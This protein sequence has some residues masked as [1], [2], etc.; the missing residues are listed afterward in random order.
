M[1][2][3]H[4]CMV[5]RHMGSKNRNSQ[6]VAGVVSRA[7]LAGLLVGLL[8]GVTSCKGIDARRLEKEAVHLYEEGKFQEAV[9]T[10]NESLALEDHMVTHHNIALAYAKLYSPSKESPENLEFANK[11][12]HHWEVYLKGKPQDNEIRDMMTKIW[13]DSS[14]FDKAISYWEAQLTAAPANREIMSRLA[15]IN[16]KAKKFTEAMDWYDKQADSAAEPAAKV[17]SYLAL[18]RV[19]YGVMSNREKVQGEERIAWADRG[20]GAIEKALA[21]APT[22]AEVWGMMGLL[23]NMR[24]IAHGPSWAGAIDRASAMPF[25]TKARALIDEEKKRKEAEAAKAMPVA[26]K[27]GN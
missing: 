11:A 26:A 1:D 2:Y 14:Q 17:T 22:N 5:R 8:A 4:F 9:N 23:L 6:G 15:G 24:A 19:A 12:A 13:V 3:T 27:Q 18:G 7:T 20:L 25:T 10:F 16:F 21:L